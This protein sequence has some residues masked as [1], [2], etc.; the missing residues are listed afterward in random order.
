MDDK[1]S[2][3]QIER[4][5]KEVSRLCCDRLVFYTPE[6]P[7]EEAQFIR[8]IIPGKTSRY[9]LTE[10]EASRLIANLKQRQPVYTLRSAEFATPS[11]R[12]RAR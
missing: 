10:K 8:E 11:D 6:H 9:D 5:K 4:I 1:I 7:L 2:V 3:S 12:R